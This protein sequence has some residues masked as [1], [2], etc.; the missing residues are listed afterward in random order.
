MRGA[1]RADDPGGEDLGEAL[2]LVGGYAVDIV[3][4]QRAAVAMLDQSALAVECPGE[5]ALFMAEQQ[6]FERGG[7]HPGAMDLAHRGLGARAGG[8][9]R[10]GEHV[11]ARSAFALDQHMRVP[12]R[13]GCCLGQRGAEGG[14]GAD[15]AVEVHRVGK[16]L[17]QR[18]EFGGGP[19]GARGACQGLQQAVG[20][21]RLD[22]VIGGARAHG[23]DGEPGR[24]AGGEHQQRRIGPRGAQI[25]DQVAG[26]VAR[27]PLVEQDRRDVAAFGRSEQCERLVAIGNGQRAPSVA[28]GKRGHQPALCRLVVDQHQHA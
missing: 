27:H 9:H 25:A 6:R 7:R 19:S 10:I 12:A 28:R 2:L 8:M 1:G 3:E 13:G 15:H 18:L 20:F 17:G 22:D 4:D 21:D 5:G 16:L 14:G 11:L 23:L 24:G 26:M